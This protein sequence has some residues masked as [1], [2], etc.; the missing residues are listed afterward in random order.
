MNLTNNT[1]FAWRVDNGLEQFLLNLSIFRLMDYSHRR[2]E[3]RV[4]FSGP[5]YDYGGV[6]AGEFINDWPVNCSI[7]LRSVECGNPSDPANGKKL[8][9]FEH[10]IPER[11]WIPHLIAGVP[12]ESGVVTAYIDVECVPRWYSQT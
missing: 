2:Y 12:R 3:W 7:E 9:V 1:I 6:N 8:V 4:I 11:R 10:C 5:F